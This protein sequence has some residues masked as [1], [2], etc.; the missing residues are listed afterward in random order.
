[1][2]SGD[3]L[4]EALSSPSSGSSLL[5]T[6]SG[7]KLGNHKTTNINTSMIHVIDTKCH[8]CSTHSS[9]EY[10]VALGKHNLVEMEEEAVFLG[11]ANIIVHEKWSSLFIR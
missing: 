6:A 11:T 2:G 9:R 5:L 1:M 10:R 3:T 4:A 8:L 7:K